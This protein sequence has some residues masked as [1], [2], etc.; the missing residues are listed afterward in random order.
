MTDP[1]LRIVRA[2]A[3]FNSAQI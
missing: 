1:A 2:I 3:P